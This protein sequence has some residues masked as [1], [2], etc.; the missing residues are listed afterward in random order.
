MSDKKSAKS[1]QVQGKA[2]SKNKGNEGAPC[3]FLCNMVPTNVPDPG[4]AQTILHPRKD[5]FVLKVAK[6]G[7]MGDRRCKM[8]LEL[9]TPKGMERKAPGRVDTRETQCDPEPC[10]CCCQKSRKPKKRK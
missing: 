6:V 2:K 10:T 3:P 4:K 5:V 7:A 8:E 9:V 1:I